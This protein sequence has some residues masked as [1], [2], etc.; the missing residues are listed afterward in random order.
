MSMDI[1]RKER[2][3]I[4]MG[5]INITEHNTDQV[6]TRFPT[7]YEREFFL[8]YL[9]GALRFSLTSRKRMNIYSY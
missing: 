4:I 8:V 5:K 2:R 7:V 1:T 3:K 6:N 9:L